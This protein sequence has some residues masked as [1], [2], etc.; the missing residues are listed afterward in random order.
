MVAPRVSRLRPLVKGN[1]DSGSEIASSVFLVLRRRSLGW[2]R[3][4]PPSEGV[5][6]VAVY[7]QIE[8]LFVT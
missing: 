7:C 2:S 8:T 6:V 5:T 1:E 4:L 3:N